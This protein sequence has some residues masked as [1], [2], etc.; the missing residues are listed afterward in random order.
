MGDESDY[1]KN[2]KTWSYFYYN[3]FSVESARDE[4]SLTV[5]EFTGLDSELFL[6]RA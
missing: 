2:D 4:Y 5:K 3:Q 6:A 1:Q